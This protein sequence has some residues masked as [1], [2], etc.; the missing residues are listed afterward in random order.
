MAAAANNDV[1]HVANTVVTHRLLKEVICSE[2]ARSTERMPDR[3]RMP[4]PPQNL[5]NVASKI[6]EYM[7]HTKNSI[8]YSSTPRKVWTEVDHASNI[9]KRGKI[10]AVKSV[11][12]QII[13][14][15][16]HE[17]MQPSSSSTI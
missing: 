12:N 10:V 6:M 11:M 16:S 9:T 17:K 5:T 15:I 1:T 8:R 4:D 13:F 7:N 3:P 2:D 14:R